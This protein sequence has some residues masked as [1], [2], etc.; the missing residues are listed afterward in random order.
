[1]DRDVEAQPGTDVIKSLVVIE[2]YVLRSFEFLGAI[3]NK[4]LTPAVNLGGFSGPEAL[5]KES[6]SS[7]SRIERHED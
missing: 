3:F 1:M 4:R 5:I 2:L 6:S 7:S